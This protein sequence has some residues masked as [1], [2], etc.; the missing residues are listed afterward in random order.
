[1]AR[2]RDSKP[3]RKLI[4]PIDFIVVGQGLAGSVLAL[5]LIESGNSVMVIDK[6]DLSLCSKVAAGIWNPIVFKRLTK[7]W[8]IDELLPEMLR[9]YKQTEINFNIKL[10]T[11]RNIVKLFSEQ[12]E[13]DLWTKKANGELQDYLDKKIY[14]SN[15]YH[16][17]NNSEFGFSKVLR[18]GN[19]DVNVFLKAA[20]NYLI[21]KESLLNEIFN[22]SELQ[23]TDDIS[24]KN[25]KAKNIIFADGYLIKN[26]PFFKYIPLKPAKGETI[27]IENQE[28]EIGKDIINKNSFL[29]HLKDNA[30]KLGATY[31]W[32]DLNDTISDSGLKELESKMNKIIIPAVGTKSKIVEQQAGVRPSVIDRRPIL[33]RHPE[34]QNLYI[35]NG[36]GTK[37]V[38]LAP[39]FAQKLINYIKFNEPLNEEVNV[40]RFTMN[41]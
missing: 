17:I 32:D 21:Q 1:V 26:N 7:S 25:V 8:M 24:Y 29:M 36:M 34:H 9:F 12:Q 5:K 14:K 31:N 13:A 15:N 30:Y 2:K 37:G 22:Y 41:K 11:E 6:P 33:G 28:L 35:F 4:K 16:G 19:L 23:I 38:M 27:T 39:Y 40:V 20:Q 18:S 10:I 3:K